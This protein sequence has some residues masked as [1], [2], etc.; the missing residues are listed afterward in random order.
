MQAG[1]AVFAPW[2][3][4]T[5]GLI[6]DL[7]METFKANSMAW[8]RVSDAVLLL[9]GWRNSNGC[10][11]EQIEASLHGVPTFESLGELL[12]FGKKFDSYECQHRTV[13][14]CGERN[15]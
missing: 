9:D 5:F 3:D 1:H 10:K 15:E 12:S 8:V 11:A 14:V 4:F 7:P 13:D 2:L 6:S